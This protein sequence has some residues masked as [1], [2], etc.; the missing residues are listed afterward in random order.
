[1]EKLNQVDYR[2][3]IEQ[4]K[5][6]LA[7]AQKNNDTP[8]MI[9]TLAELGFKLFMAHE[10]E[11]GSARFS[12]AIALADK[13][14]NI[15]LKVQCLGKKALAYQEINRL[16]DAFQTVDE[17]LNIAEQQTDAGLKCDAL[18]SQAQILIDS[19][20]PNIALEKL[21]EARKLANDLNDKRRLMNVLGVLG[22]QSIAITSL[23]HA[24]VYF[25][26]ASRLAEELGDTQARFGHLGNK[27]S[28][29][30][31]QC[32]YR[33]A[34]PEFEKVLVFVRE[35]GNLGAEIQALRHLAQAHC[36]LNENEKALEYAFPGIELC[37]KDEIET[38]FP[39]YETVITV[40]YRQQKIQ[41]AQLINQEA[42]NC[43]HEINN[44]AKELEFLL[45]L[46]ETQYLSELPEEAMETYQRA[47]KIAK[48]LNLKT[49]EAY[50]TGRIG[51]TLAEVGRLDEAIKYHSQ[52]VDFAKSLLL[53]N[54]EGEQLSMLA[55]AFFEKGDIQEA[56]NYCNLAIQVFTEAEL[57]DEVQKAS[58]LLEKID[59]H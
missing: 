42:I 10:F 7:F 23:D 49:D 6:D 17:I 46:G 50:L 28:V 13:I 4:H 15:D 36:K 48:Q 27:G 40:Y 55:M 21:D 59:S 2:D 9:S 38:I 25:D 56:R 58:Q 5:N 8:E 39:F 11:D 35:Q 33:E 14:Q 44:Y 3:A 51:V 19:G 37:K 22:N 54:L 32:N 52:A 26:K 24:E 41:E 12:A 16:Y 1:M 57:K 20:E 18:T 53:P 30:V 31:W 29:L 43:A 34:I 47:C 45:S